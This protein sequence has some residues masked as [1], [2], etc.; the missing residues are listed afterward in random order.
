MK[1]FFFYVILLIM[2]SVATYANTETIDISGNNTSSSYKTYNTPISISAMDTLDVKMARYTYFS[3]RIIGTGTLNLLAGG[4]RGYLGTAKGAAWPDWSS[5][6]GDVHI[7]PYKENSPGAGFYGV[8]LAHGGKSFS[9]ENIVGALEAGRMNQSM[10]SNKVVLHNG[11]TICCEANT[12]GAG[13]RIG[14]LQMETGSVLQGYIKKGRAC[15]Y[16]LGS[17]NTD[18]VLAGTL[19]PSGYDNATMMGIL[20]E[21][22]GTYRIT[23][24]DNLLTG[25][26]RI[27][28]GKVCV[29]NDRTAAERER[30]RGG[31]GALPNE[32]TPVAYVFE[33]GVLGGTGSIG[34]L[35][36]NYGVIAPGDET[37]GTLTLCNYVTPDKNA[38]LVTHPASVLRFRVASATN[39][40][41]LEVNGI[42]KYSTM[43]EDFS[44]SEEEPVVELNVDK[45]ANLQVGDELVLL[46]ARQ[47]DLATHWHFALKQPTRYSWTLEERASDNRY[48]LVA[49]VNSVEASENPG[50]SGETGTPDTPE[51]TLGYLYPDGIDEQADKNTLRYYA[52]KNSKYIG[53]AVSTWKANF[54][55][56]NSAENKEVA[57]Q[58]N[59]IVAENEMKT[60]ALQPSRASFSYGGADAIVNF[61]RANKM[62]VRGHCLVWHQQQP[63]WISSDGKRND[64]NWSRQEALKIMEEHITNVMRHFKGKIAEWD[65]VNECL[66]DD[67]SIVRTNLNGY[68]FRQTVWQRAI[69]DDYIDSAFVYAHRA[70]PSA[71]LFIND[72]DVEMQGT[73]KAVAY[74]NLV[75]HLKDRQIPVDGV[76]LQCH[77]SAGDVDSVKLDATIRRFGEMGLKCSITE[78]DMGVKSVSTAHLEEQARNYRIIT[79][80]VLNNDN[81]ESL[82]IWGLKDN[83]SWRSTFN[84]LLYTAALSKKQA[85]YGVRSALRHRTVISGVQMVKDVFEPS[86]VGKKIVFNL[87]GQRV[88]ERTLRP[89]IYISEGKR[90]IVK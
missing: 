35:V 21:G 88:N 23:G 28:E 17:R 75:K 43:R 16:M 20:K 64:K 69:G 83:D 32:N 74:C 77:F 24:N 58:F 59:M 70:D 78:L 80:V 55:V 84:P 27:L 8:V 22:I 53:T 61:A 50:G 90:L 9:P 10:Q 38:D 63:S 14:E 71:K 82:V 73:A 19:K 46:T 56:A 30:K 39:Y 72:Y 89:G 4:E 54:N 42:L 29:N 60:D 44:V 48:V 45:Q 6:H 41:R 67:Q 26:L 49:K 51:T 87:R 11:A 57:S 81:C 76:G 47:K 65:V 52:G 5:F 79:D 33:K 13:F 31:L 68:S 40:D 37:I 1:R 34:G 62:A 66:D 25:G 3:S 85:Y 86:N 7:Y 2:A 36:D 18:G 15:Y 12:S